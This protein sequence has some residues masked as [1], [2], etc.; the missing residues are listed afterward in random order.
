[1]QITFPEK[2]FLSPYSYKTLSVLLK[3]RYL[4]PLVV[5]GLRSFQGS[6][7]GREIIKSFNDNGL[8][9]FL[10]EGISPE[11]DICF[12]EKG[13]KLAINTD[14]HSIDHLR[15]MQFGIAAARR[16]WAEKKDI[17]NALPWKKF[18]KLL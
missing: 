12:V 11:P 13:L 4:K 5:V 3:E 9:F 7:W 15:F 17:I 2:L 10:F 18:E 14:A 1:M 8:D 6:F 16:G